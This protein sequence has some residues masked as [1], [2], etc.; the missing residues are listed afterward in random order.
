MKAA[1]VEHPKQNKTPDV[2]DYYDTS[3]DAKNRVGLRG[4]TAKYYHVRVL[5]NGGYLLEPRV[6]VPPQYVSE[7]TLKM[8]SRSATNLKKGRAS[9]PIDLSAFVEP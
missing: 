8:L 5:S 7:R 3:A 4:A 2:I 1:I 6:L 9:A